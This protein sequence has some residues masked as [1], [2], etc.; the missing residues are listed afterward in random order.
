MLNNQMKNK[1]FQ[2][3]KYSSQLS[4]KMDQMISNEYNNNTYKSNK[5]LDEMT[6]NSEISKF[7]SKSNSIHI[8][9]ILIELYT[10]LKMRI[11]LET[12]LHPQ[13]KEM[14]SWIKNNLRLID[15]Q[16]FEIKHINVLVDDLMEIIK[17]EIKEK[18]I[19]EL[20]LGT[21]L[22]FSF[23]DKKVI[24]Y[25]KPIYRPKAISEDSKNVIDP[26]QNSKIII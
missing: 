9:K 8:E 23:S 11:T 2:N 14:K 18:D 19:E 21:N 22:K 5:S 10:I 4:P 12:C 6:S 15:L 25:M 16:H 1:I 3:N 13:E 7:Y 24:D 17:D 26:F 20:C